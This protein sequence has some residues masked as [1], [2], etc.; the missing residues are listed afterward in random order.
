MCCRP[1]ARSMCLYNAIFELYFTPTYVR[2]QNSMARAINNDHALALLI[3]P[4]NFIP[5]GPLSQTTQDFATTQEILFLSSQLSVATSSRVLLLN[6]VAS[7]LSHF[8]C[9]PL[10]SARLYVLYEMIMHNVLVTIASSPCHRVI[11]SRIGSQDS[12][13]TLMFCTVAQWETRF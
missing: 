9:A 5:R 2:G 12:E 13:A 7:L 11:T 1:L 6:H 3:P 10:P 8:L 4:S